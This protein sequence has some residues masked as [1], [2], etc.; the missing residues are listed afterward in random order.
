VPRAYP[1]LGGGI[2]KKII[3]EVVYTDGTSFGGPFYGDFS[4]SNEQ[5]VTRS[6]RVLDSDSMELAF[7]SEEYLDKKRAQYP[8]K[9]EFWVIIPDDVILVPEEYHTKGRWR[10]YVEEYMTSIGKA[11][12]DWEAMARNR[13]RNFEVIRSS[14]SRALAKAKSLCAPDSF[15]VNSSRVDTNRVFVK[16]LEGA[17]GRWERR[18]QHIYHVS[19]IK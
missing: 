11:S 15:V 13:P 7:Y 5:R 9:K 4:A 1:F 6:I 18:I 19:C 2:D 10:T 3:V 16:R 17:G 12:P 8:T 14:K